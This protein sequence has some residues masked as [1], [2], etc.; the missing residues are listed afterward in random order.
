[1]KKKYE[2]LIEY[3]QVYH[4]LALISTKLMEIYFDKCEKKHLYLS[5]ILLFI[6]I[7]I[8]WT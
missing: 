5:R 3:F 6:K 8:A 7:D 1:M 2:T 4:T